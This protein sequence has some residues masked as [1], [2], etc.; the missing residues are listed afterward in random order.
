MLTED[1]ESRG[2][3]SLSQL[4]GRFLRQMTNELRSSHER[5]LRE[6]AHVLY[7]D[8]GAIAPETRP[9]TRPE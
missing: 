1:V 9:D 8:V 6:Y 5:R 7:F 3:A 4:N 2:I